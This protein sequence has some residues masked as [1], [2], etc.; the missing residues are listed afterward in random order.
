MHPFAAMNSLIS[1]ARLAPE[2]QAESDVGFQPDRPSAPRTKSSV[3]VDRALGLR[4][5]AGFV[6]C[7]AKVGGRLKE[8]DG[9]DA[10]G[11]GQAQNHGIDALR[12]HGV[13]NSQHAGAEHSGIES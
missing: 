3:A 6:A 5:I 10:H 7:Q 4:L 8:G 12:R 13:V 2:T 11:T 9:L 1:R